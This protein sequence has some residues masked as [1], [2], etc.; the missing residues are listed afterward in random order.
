MA[1]FTLSAP[2]APGT[3][4]YTVYSFDLAEFVVGNLDDCCPA[5]PDAEAKREYLLGLADAL[6]QP[7]FLADL[8][9]RLQDA[10]RGPL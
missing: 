3:V 8:A 4:D 10:A 2:A 6:S 9:R 7:T 5:F 1:S